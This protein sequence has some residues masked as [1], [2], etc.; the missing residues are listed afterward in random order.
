MSSNQISMR[1]MLEAGVHFGHQKR[2]WNPKM[3]NYIYGTRQRIHII[4]LE[5]SLPMFRDCLAFLSKIAK[6]RGKILFVGTKPAAREVIREEAT[7]CGMPYVN[8]RWLGGMLTNYKTLRQSIR[9]L[10]DLESM[11]EGKDFQKLTKKEK[12]NLLREQEKLE[13]CLSG[14]KN[15]G[16]LPDA[17]F[18]IDVNNEKNAV[19]EANRLGI[20]VVAVV[21]TNC[22]PAGIDYMV[23]GN[24]DA[25]RSI[26]FYCKQLADV[27]I[28]ARGDILRE[29]QEADAKKP[30]VTRKVTAK[31]GV[32]EEAATQSAE[33]DEGVEEKAAKTVK[34]VTRIK[35]AADA[36]PESD[37][38]EDAK[39]AKKK[40]TT[41][42]K[43]TVKKAAAK[44]ATADKSASE[45][46]SDAASE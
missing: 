36:E 30:K 3:A 32:T 24:D 6:N 11:A 10:R 9:R 25:L 31:D 40:T 4:N 20:P 37:D 15:M 22:D 33:Q 44:K 2:F 13:A 27:I 1:D 26:R 17:L 28:D 7:R 14:I 23:P 19:R 42:K 21:D 38:A 34:K 39:T 41:K 18:V 16:G 8:Y 35:T 12:L 45:E 5:K 43:T 46:A 29:Q